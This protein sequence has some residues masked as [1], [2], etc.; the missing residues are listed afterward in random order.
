MSNIDVATFQFNQLVN[1]DGMSRVAAI[2]YVTR[3]LVESTDL[4]DEQ[5]VKIVEAIAG[6]E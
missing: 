2:Y 1:N 5:A 3:Y 6:A 4:T